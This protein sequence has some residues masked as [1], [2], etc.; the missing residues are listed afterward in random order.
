MR[1]GAV[2]MTMTVVM[3]LAGG[4]AADSPAEKA[5]TDQN[6]GS[7]TYTTERLDRDG[8]DDCSDAVDITTSP[9]TDTGNTTGYADD[10]GPSVSGY[11]Q[12]GEDQAYRLVITVA[13]NMTVSVTPTG[14][15]CSVYVI[16]DSDCAN[17]MPTVLAGADTAFTGETETIV[18]G[19]SPGTYIIVVDSYLPGEVGPFDLEVLSTVPVEL[20]AFSV[21]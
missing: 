11:G 16:S 12:D 14:Y 1:Y 17:Y 3:I 4:V 6:P 13:G 18:F 10:W 9:Y 5:Q 15:D 8:G 7:A 21:E 2:A 19:A 20:T